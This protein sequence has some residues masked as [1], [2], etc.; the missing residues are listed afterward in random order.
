MSPKRAR[1]W[2]YTLFDIQHSAI[3]DPNAI[4]VPCS[5]DE[6]SRLNKEAEEKVRI[7]LEEEEKNYAKSQSSDSPSAS[8]QTSEQDL[9]DHPGSV[10]F[11]LK[12]FPHHPPGYTPVPKSAPVNEFYQSITDWDLEYKNRK[13]RINYVCNNLENFADTP[14]NNINHVYK[15]WEELDQELKHPTTAE[16]SSSN[17]T[18]GFDQPWLGIMHAESDRFRL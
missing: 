15:I 14:R 9:P 12:D 13:Q 10:K 3:D 5:D 8:A 11:Y 16:N 18:K 2:I 7:L 1:Y 4:N 6:L 17:S